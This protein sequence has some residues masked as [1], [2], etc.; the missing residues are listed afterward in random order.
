MM[1]GLHE[2]AKEWKNWQNETKTL[3]S[4]LYQR[5]NEEN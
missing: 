3:G 5:S 2:G 4:H 1:E